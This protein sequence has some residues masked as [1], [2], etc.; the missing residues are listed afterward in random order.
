MNQ[1]VST[2]TAILASCFDYPPGPDARNKIVYEG[3]Q[4]PTV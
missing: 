2:I 1:N 3:L 4:F